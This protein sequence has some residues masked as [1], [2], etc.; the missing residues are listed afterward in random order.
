L[1]KSLV[2]GD[3][4]A[5]RSVLLAVGGA[6]GVRVVSCLGLADAS[7]VQVHLCQGLG[8]LSIVVDDHE[9]IIPKV[10]SRLL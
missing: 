1:E 5:R 6:G 4:K 3:E 7:A 8:N 2:G 9:I 10:I